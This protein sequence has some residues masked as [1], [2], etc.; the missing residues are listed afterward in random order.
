MLETLCRAAK[1][2]EQRQV[3]ESKQMQ[4]QT[5]KLV[6]GKSAEKEVLYS[7]FS[8]LSLPPVRYQNIIRLE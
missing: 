8:P 1:E 2:E 7:L 4:R 6:R 5:S 3:K